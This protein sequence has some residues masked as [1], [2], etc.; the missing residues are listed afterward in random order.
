MAQR[1]S[2]RKKLTIPPVQWPTEQEGSNY[3]TTTGDLNLIHEY[4]GLNFI[5][6]MGL[7]LFTYAILL[8]DAVITHLS[9]T[10]EGAEMLARAW[11]LEQTDAN[12]KDLGTEAIAIYEQD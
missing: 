7:R 6:I 8:R 1:S 4:T 2:S 5:E 3:S 12:I 10:S 11:V 9:A